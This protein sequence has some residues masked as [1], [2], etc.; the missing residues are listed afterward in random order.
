MLIRRAVV[1]DAVAL[2]ELLAVTPDAPV[3][4]KR[5]WEEM[6]R[7]Q[8]ESDSPR[9]AL[10]VAD[11][12]GGKLAGVIAVTLLWPVTEVELL[13]VRP[14]Y[15]RRGIGRLL[16]RE[17]LAWADEGGAREALLEVRRSNGGAQAL[18]RQLGFEAQGIRGGYYRHPEED[19]VMMRK[20]LA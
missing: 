16:S 14:E 3:W 12:E 9:R 18:Y 1:E 6:L 7:R 10:F 2:R 5:V 13:A 11:E 15:R 8:A 20:E 17:W 19:A 4:P